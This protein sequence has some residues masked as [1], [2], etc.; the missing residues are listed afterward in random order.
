MR[1]QTLRSG[2]LTVRVLDALPDGARPHTLVVLCHGFGA[3]GD[4]LVPIAQMLLRQDPEGLAGVRFA[5]PH[6]PHSLDAIGMPGGRAWWHLDL[7]TL[8]A[9][10]TGR[11]ERDRRDEIPDGL[12]PA[13]RQL[14]ATIDGLLRDAGL[15]VS[16]LVLGGFSQGAMITTDLA[17]RLEEAPAGLCI[18]SGTLLCRP[19]WEER[20]KRRAGLKVV[21][22]HGRQDP[23]LPFRFAEELRDLLRAADLSVEFV[24][25]NGQ[26]TIPNAAM[27]AY[28]TLLTGIAEAGRASAP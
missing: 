13:R 5:L 17:L 7:A 11:L 15:P 25:F 1:L 19:Q 28:H 3:P 14:Q 22:S 6:A 10:A 20:A 18:F 27:R 21:Q 9:A 16:R 26:H 12:A 4:D 8:Q 24:P 2:P 23:L